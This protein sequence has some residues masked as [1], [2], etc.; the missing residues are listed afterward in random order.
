MCVCLTSI[1]CVCLTSIVCV[2]CM[3][4]SYYVC[5]Y[6]VLYYV[7]ILLCTYVSVC[8]DYR[9]Y[10]TGLE[11][12]KPCVRRV[13]WRRGPLVMTVSWQRHQTVGKAQFSL[14]CCSKMS[15]MLPLSLRFSGKTAA[16]L[17]REVVVNA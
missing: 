6:V 10:L 17:T 14:R 4:I 8:I 3:C 1:V 15:N 7:C 2:C 12:C 13:P 5:V 9:A 16:I 11:T